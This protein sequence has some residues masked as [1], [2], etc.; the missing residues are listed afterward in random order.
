[1][2]TITL[3]VSLASVLTLTA[4]AASTKG[5]TLCASA[6]VEIDCGITAEACQQALAADDSFRVENDFTLW[7]VSLDDDDT[8]GS[9]RCILRAH[10]TGST[11][12]INFG[13]PADPREIEIDVGE[14]VAPGR[15]LEVEQTELDEDDQPEIS[16]AA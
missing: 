13:P 15:L 8:D 14:A 6:D 12:A 1:M 2:K 3:A 5:A 10:D 7:S 11:S 4:C 9:P 16:D